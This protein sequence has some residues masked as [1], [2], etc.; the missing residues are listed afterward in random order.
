MSEASFPRLRAGTRGSDLALWQTRDVA[1]RLRAAHPEI[2]V[3]P[4]VVTTRGDVD[5]SDRLVGRLDK[6]FFTRELEDLLRAGGVDI[7][8]HSLKDLPTVQPEGLALGAVVER[9]NVA[10]WLLVRRDAVV[11]GE[12]VV[13]PSQN[14]L[15]LRPGAR[16]G[17]SALRR[18]AL[19]QRY[20]PQATAVPLRG[21][22]PTRVH[23]L[24]ERTYDAIVLAAAG[25]TRLGL[26]L[27]E[28]AVFELDPSLW[29]PAP[30]QGAVAVQCRADD[31][32]TLA[33]LAALDHRATREAVEVERALLR[34]TEG[35]CNSPFG[36]WSDGRCV[37]WGLARADRWERRRAPLDV[38]TA[39]LQYGFR[40]VPVYLD[41]TFLLGDD[42]VRLD[43]QIH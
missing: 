11:G 18:E 8:V 1:E 9:A 12:N 5:L 25:V 16:V 2:E 23:K 40:E 21:N 7:V 24:R 10:D 6:G 15:P 33:R 13:R 35:G 39:A 30:G 4:V 37:T 36:A 22:V 14:R 42:D 32:A 31:A 29:V 34:L 43:S 27:S 20:A 41:D 26:D 19:V 17:S 3:E 38:M 28:L